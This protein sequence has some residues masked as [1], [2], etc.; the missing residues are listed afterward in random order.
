MKPAVQTTASDAGDREEGLMAHLALERGGESNAQRPPRPGNEVMQSPEGYAP[1][2][3]RYANIR[4]RPK[5]RA[6]RTGT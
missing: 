5:G 3:A 1:A 6:F 2:H 4:K